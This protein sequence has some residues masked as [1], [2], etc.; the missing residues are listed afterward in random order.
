M[1][2]HPSIPALLNCQESLS[3]IKWSAVIFS[4]GNYSVWAYWRTCVKGR[5]GGDS[6]ANMF[7]Y[8]IPLICPIPIKLLP[9]PSETLWRLCVHSG[10]TNKVI[11][12]LG[13]P[14]L[15]FRVILCERYSSQPSS[16]DVFFWRLDPEMAQ[17]ANLS[18]ICMRRSFLNRIWVATVRWLPFQNLSFPF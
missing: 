7:M 4:F 6:L 10:K 5:G 17:A 12:N 13:S 18:H 8:L 11:C 16:R 15:V 1:N 14:V 9:F 3:C 2:L